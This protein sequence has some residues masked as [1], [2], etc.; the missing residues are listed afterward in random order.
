MPNMPR[1]AK[2]PGL[3]PGTLIYTGEKREDPV[4]I[5]IFD[6]SLSVFED[7]EDATFED[8]ECSLTDDTAT[9]VNFSHVH[10]VD[11]IQRLGEKYNLHHLILE[12]LV[13]VTQRPKLEVYEDHIYIVAKMLRYEGEGKLVTEQVSFVLAKNYILSF[14]EHPG[15]VFD[16]VRA[17]LRSGKGIIRKM[18]A[19]YMAYALLDLIV[20]HFF[21]VLERLGEEIEDLE[22]EVIEEPSKQ[23]MARVNR[24]KREVLMYRKSVWPLREVVAGMERDESGLIKKKTQTYLRDV[25]DHTIQAADMLETYRDLLGGLTDLY[26]SSLSHKMNEV[27][28]VLTIVGAIFIPLTFIAGIYGMNFAKMPELQWDYGYP[29]VWILMLCVSAGLV[30]FFRHKKWI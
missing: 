27:M 26:L 18:G 15:D 14:Q 20:D 7:L 8:I 11:L 28:Q 22:V 4:C 1:I 9:W 2:K 19:D 16:P 3:A 17:R 29:A 24:L 23:T 5:S 25:Y 12:D 13:N 21:I 6:Y 10:D 30:L